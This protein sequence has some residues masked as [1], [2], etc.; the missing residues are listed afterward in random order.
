MPDESLNGFIYEDTWLPAGTPIEGID[1]LLAEHHAALAQYEYARRPL[2]EAHERFFHEDH[3]HEQRL[4][5]WGRSGG[6]GE[7]PTKTPEEERKRILAPLKDAHDAANAVLIGVAERIEREF[8][9]HIE[10]WVAHA[11]EVKAQAHSRASELRREADEAEARVAG[12]D[13]LVRWMRITAHPGPFGHQPS[14]EY[15]TTALP[16]SEP[17]GEEPGMV[18]ISEAGAEAGTYSMK[19]R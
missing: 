11:Q 15:I 10:E 1:H 12:I 17:R 2:M 13:G 4:R 7:Q 5:E 14:G 18:E 8:R 6:A 3:A 9:E 16:E 19:A